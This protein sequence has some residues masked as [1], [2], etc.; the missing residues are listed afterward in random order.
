MVISQHTTTWI[1]YTAKGKNL[2]ASYLFSPS[3]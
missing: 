2:L 3:A 1:I